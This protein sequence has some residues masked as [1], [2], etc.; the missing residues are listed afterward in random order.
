M[1]LSE[2]ST[3]PKP[4]SIQEPEMPED[5]FPK[6]ESRLGQLLLFGM[7]FIFFLLVSAISW[8]TLGRI[9]DQTRAD[10]TDSLKTIL[11]TTHSAL[12]IWEFERKA[13]FV[14]WA[15]SN[16]LQATV[17]E[18]LKVPRSREVLMNATAQAKLR[19]LLE[20]K[21][22]VH[23]YSGYFVIAPD[24]SNIGSM[25]DSNLVKT[26]L[27]A[28]QGDFLKRIFN[29]ETLVSHPLIS[30]VPLLNTYTGKMVEGEPIMFV[31][32]PIL[33]EEGAVMAALGF[34]LN[35]ATDFTRVL[36]LGRTGKTGETYAFNSSG[37]LLSESRFDQDLRKI[38]LISK[39]KRGILSIE[40]RDPGG[41]L[42]NGFKSKIPRN[43]QPFTKMA[44]IAISRRAGVD[45]EGYRNYRGVN[46][47]GA[48]LW[49]HSMEF[50]LVT[51]IEAEEAYRSFNFTRRLILFAIGLT[52][53]I[54]VGLTL[55]VNIG[56]TRALNLM[57]AVDVGR[58]RALHFAKIAQEREARIRAVVDNVGDGIITIDEEGVI[59]SFSPAAEKIFGYFTPEVVGQNIKILMPEPHK[60]R[61][62][63]YIKNYLETEIS[64]IVGIGREEEGMRRDGTV[65]P[66]D[67]AI[68]EV[69]L[70]D[71]RIFI[72]TIRD[73]T[74]RKQAEDGLKQS[75][76]DLQMA[77][78]K[79]KESMDRVQEAHRSLVASEKLAGIGGL[80]EG[81]CNEVLNILNAISSNVQRVLKKTSD[82]DLFASL[83]KTRQETKRIEKIIQSLLK[84]SS[85]E[86]AKFKAVRI[87]EELDSILTLVEHHMRSDDIKVVREF[88]PDLPK[89]TV[90]PD[91][92]EQV[93][94]YIIDNAR[95]AMPHGGT[96]VASTGQVTK[97]GSSYIRIKIADTGTGIKKADLEK[98]FEAFYSSK[99]EGEGTGMGLSLC[100]TLIQKHGGTIDVDSEW[101]KGTTFTIDLPLQSDRKP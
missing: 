12:H 55:I 15:S 22:R 67:V 6:S 57:A 30:D 29:G 90:N 58:A 34:R 99:P 80:T 1:K 23:D 35:P 51:E 25:R 64:K 100:R 87:Y 46:V 38:G 74:A 79:L 73:I 66:L 60:S 7:G 96:L 77:H 91:E 61:P 31:V 65:F 40:I 16:K 76:Y 94:L 43:K 28:G 26:N 45:V 75:H 39:G 14:T 47:V 33:D 59:E 89:I 10:L 85:K 69:W 50:A 11:R 5:G 97:N 52:G 19:T 37:T 98:I 81:V 88:D 84:F 54:A 48:W 93:F 41:D 27:L 56:R 18:L 3:V 53:F 17:K 95:H 8:Y 9:E 63:S 24:F 72:G 36:Q 2:N 68:N 62:D 4:K 78:Q 32:A 83:D 49:D 21:L 42:V 13:D 82:S 20:P 70:E 86:G 101:G 92:M 71:R 44:E